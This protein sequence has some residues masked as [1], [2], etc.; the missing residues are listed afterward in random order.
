MGP[1]P[2]YFTT[3]RS[4]CGRELIVNDGALVAL[5]ARSGSV[6]GLA[7]S[8]EIDFPSSGFAVQGRRAFVAGP[9]AA[10]EVACR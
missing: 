5:D 3:A 10:Y 6:V 9:R 4:L 1:A 2:M 7:L 8:E